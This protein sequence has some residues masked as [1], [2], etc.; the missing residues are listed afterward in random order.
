MVV[1]QLLYVSPNPNKAGH[2]RQGPIPAGVGGGHYAPAYFGG[3]PACARNPFQ[4]G[5]VGSVAT[6]VPT[7]R[8]GARS[9]QSAAAPRSSGE[10]PLI[11]N[12]LNAVAKLRG[13]LE[14]QVP[15]VLQHLLLQL[16]DEP[17]KRLG[18]I[19]YVHG[20]TTAVAVA[21]AP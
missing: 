2:L 19:R 3:G 11:A 7:S 6:K 15:G 20:H 10:Y 16:I 13:L 8:P 17:A 4:Q 21:R 9:R 14:F 12:R 1:R 5:L 18:I